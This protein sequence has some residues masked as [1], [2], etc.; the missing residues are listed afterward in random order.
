M[1]FLH[2][3]RTVAKTVVLQNYI[4][5]CMNTHNIKWI[6]V[7]IGH[8]DLQE[9]IIWKFIGQDDRQKLNLPSLSIFSSFLMECAFLLGLWLI[10]SE[11][12]LAYEGEPPLS[13]IKWQPIATTTKV[14]SQEYLHLCFIK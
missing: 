6:T 13:K 12:L 11:T 4:F 7:K 14:S 3:S 10:R 5:V 1:V 9:L 8:W 2:S